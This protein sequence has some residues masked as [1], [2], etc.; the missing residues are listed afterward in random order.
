MP[1]ERIRFDSGET[2]AILTTPDAAGPFPVVLLCHGFLSSKESATNQALSQR[3]PAVGIATLRFD[4]FGHGESRSPFQDLTLTRCLDQ[5]EAALSW[6]KTGGYPRIGLIGGSFGGLVALHTAARCANLSVLGLKCPVFD[7]PPLWQERLGEAG[8]R[9]WREDGLLSFVGPS[10]K[11]RL[12]YSFYEDLLQYD[13]ERAA[14]E[15]RCPTR[16]VHGDADEY[17]PVSQSQKLLAHIETEKDLV[18]LSGANHD[19]SE[20]FHFTRMIDGLTDW[21][22]RWLV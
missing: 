22:V 4:F 12:G 15:I 19:F 10:G 14:A 16:I 3:L 13:G 2:A 11:A 21:M 18:L 20:A 7:Y 1:S 8:M 5:T 17:V 6:L 9:G